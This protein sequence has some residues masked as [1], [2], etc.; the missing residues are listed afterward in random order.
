MSTASDRGG[1]HGAV[2]DDLS[3]HNIGNTSI[4]DVGNK[5]ISATIGVVLH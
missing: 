1:T 2:G 4:K 5:P 3:Y